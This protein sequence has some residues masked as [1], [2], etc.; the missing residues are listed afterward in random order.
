MLGQPKYNVNDRVSFVLDNET[1]EGSIYIVDAFGT[2]FQTEEPSYDIM[3][4]YHGTNILVKHI[5]ESG[6]KKI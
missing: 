1:Y 3:T 2:F 5:R 6:L 4:N